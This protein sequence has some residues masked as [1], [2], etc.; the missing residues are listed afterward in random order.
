MFSIF[1][2]KNNFFVKGSGWMETYD[3]YALDELIHQYMDDE[4]E[5]DEIVEFCDNL[6]PSIKN[7]KMLMDSI[8]CYDI[9]ILYVTL[10]GKFKDTL[11]VEEAKKYRDRFMKTF[12][13]IIWL[14]TGEIYDYSRK[15][16]TSAFISLKDN[17]DK[18]WPSYRIF[19]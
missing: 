12:D 3:E 8:D 19:T 11:S 6:E 14:H 1:W 13:H 9:E 4:I 15:K 5:L 7:K 17:W 18:D 10:F 16:K 2:Q